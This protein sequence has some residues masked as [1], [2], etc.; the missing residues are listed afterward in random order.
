MLNQYV[1][2]EY[3]VGRVTNLIDCTGDETEETS[4]AVTLVA[5]L[6]SGKW[7]TGFL[8]EVRLITVQ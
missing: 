7:F 2:T 6:E 1:N 5:R 3:G 4:E 8:E